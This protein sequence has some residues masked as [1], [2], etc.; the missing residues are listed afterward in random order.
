MDVKFASLLNVASTKYF[1]KSCAISIFVTCSCRKC[2]MI[3]IYDYYMFY[4]F[5][6]HTHSMRLP[7]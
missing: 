4:I 5:F 7:K 6:N 1:L 2:Y 3:G